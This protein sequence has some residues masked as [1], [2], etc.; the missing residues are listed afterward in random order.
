MIRYGA[1]P[2]PWSTAVWRPAATGA[3]HALETQTV[4]PP[5]ELRVLRTDPPRPAHA[6]SADKLHR[7]RRQRRH[8]WAERGCRTK[9][10]QPPPYVRSL[11]RRSRL[12]TRQGR[13]QRVVGR[14][15]RRSSG[16]VTDTDALTSLAR[17]AR[18]PFHSPRWPTGVGS[19]CALESLVCARPRGGRTSHVRSPGTWLINSEGARTRTLAPLVSMTTIAPRWIVSGRALLA[20]LVLATACLPRQRCSRRRPP[21]PSRVTAR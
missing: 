4:R 13:G 3:A 15:P 6:H 7:S 8:A 12:G 16:V 20:P 21:W 17:V 2:V 10:R 18:G 1:F 9:G 5:P 11:G 19:S 14:S